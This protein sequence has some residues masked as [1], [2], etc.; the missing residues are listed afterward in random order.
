M[1][2][3]T[4][5]YLTPCVKEVTGISNPAVPFTSLVAFFLLYLQNYNTSP[6]PK[7]Q[8]ATPK[9]LPDQDNNKYIELLFLALS[10]PNTLAKDQSKHICIVLGASY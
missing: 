10:A 4:E 9:D 3:K 6:I 1:D 5:T 2:V 8:A 7:H